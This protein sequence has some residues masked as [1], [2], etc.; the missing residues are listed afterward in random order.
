RG[1]LVREL[2]E[3]DRTDGARTDEAHVAAQ[4]VDELRD[5]V[6][7]R[8]LEPLAD[9]RELVLCTPHEL[10]PEVRAE[11]CLRVR[12]QRPELQHREDAAAAADALAAVQDRAAAREE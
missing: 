11:P 3:E 1:Q 7:L 2:L 8:R 4:H 5:L 9:R 6:E 12:L 10:L